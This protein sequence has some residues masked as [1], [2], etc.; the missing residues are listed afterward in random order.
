MEIIE[1]ALASDEGYICGLIVTAASMAINASKDV[2][3]RFHILDCGITDM[4][5]NEIV[6]RVKPWH[7]NLLFE[8]HIIDNSCLGKVPS[9]HGTKALYARLLLPE[10]LSNTHYVVYCDVDFLW[11]GNVAELWAM[12]SDDFAAWCVRDQSK[13]TIETEARW[14]ESHGLTFDANNYFCSGL[15]FM[16]L[17]RFRD[18]NYGRLAFEFICKYPD[19]LYPDQAA[20]NYLLHNDVCFVDK[21]WQQLTALLDEDARIRPCVYHFAGDTPWKRRFIVN[22][23]TDA[24]L[25]WHRYYARIYGISVFGALHRFFSIGQILYRRALW[26]AVGNSATRTIIFSLLAVIGK[27]ECIRYLV[28]ARKSVYYKMP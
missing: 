16:N 7:P 15:C 11:L 24:V 17:K 1:I 8:R 14:H 13:E 21:K 6:E 5:Y 26:F 18:C 10:I 12:K 9:W 20:L 22:M 2:A 4:G 28:D 19:V 25:L 3:I 23:L 27:H